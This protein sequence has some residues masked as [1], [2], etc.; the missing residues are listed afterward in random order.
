[1]KNYNIKGQA[2][3]NKVEKL[4]LWKRRGNKRKRKYNKKNTIQTTDEA[5]TRTEA[6]GLDLFQHDT[7][8]SG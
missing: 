6:M 4:F 8:L 7:N 2:T 5:R 1:M 3:Q